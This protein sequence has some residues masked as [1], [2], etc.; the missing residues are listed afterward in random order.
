MANW[1]RFPN[2]PITE[3]LLD[4]RAKFPGSLDLQRLASFH[5]TVK[6][7]YPDK[8]EHFSWRSGFQMKP[9][10][11]VDVVQPSG[12][13]DGYSFASKD[14]LQ[15]VQARMNGFTLN[16]LKPYDT[17]EVFR[18]EAKK[19]WY[20]FCAITTPEIVPRVALRYI[21]RL[22]IPLPIS[23]FL[24]YIRTVPEVAPQLPQGLS[25]FLM[26][27]V[28]PALHRNAIAIV[29]E[30]MEP[31]QAKTVPLIFD[32]DV[33]E[34]GAFDVQGTEMWDAYAQLREFKN[35]IFF[36]SITEKAAEL[37]K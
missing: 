1:P 29:T 31:P 2:A 16:R 11:T 13:T 14:G 15:I 33:F 37:F 27:L 20:R 30:A 19:Q 6:D 10:G 22:Q 18:D 24:D 12:G 35:E 32:I 7:R 28:I 21:N 5:E 26:R 36:G 34:E 4:I 8:R 9:G 17:W 23:D 25:S 3:A